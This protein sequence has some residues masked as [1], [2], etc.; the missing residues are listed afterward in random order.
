MMPPASSPACGTSIGIGG[1]RVPRL[2]K[3]GL[4][5]RKPSPKGLLILLSA[6]LPKRQGPEQARGS[7]FAL[8][9]DFRGLP[10]PWVQAQPHFNSH[11]HLV[12]FLWL[13]RFLGLEAQTHFESRLPLVYFFCV[14]R[15]L[16]LLA[17]AHFK[18][19]LPLVFFFV[20][21]WFLWLQASVLFTLLFLFVLP[22][23]LL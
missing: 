2:G 3:H 9:L 21:A 15:S 5:T 14:P 10:G 22:L 20:F 12:Q 19:H 8:G 11:L 6:W 23:F 4:K 7:S 17:H 1:C 18:S 13:P 16:G